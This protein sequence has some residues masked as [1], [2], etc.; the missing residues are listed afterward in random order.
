MTDSALAVDTRPDRDARTN[1]ASVPSSV[2]VVAGRSLRKYMRTPQV[3]LWATLQGIAFMLIFRYVFGGAIDS[4][5][6]RYVDF[7]VPGILVAGVLFAGGMA[8]VGVAQ[9]LRQ[10]VYDRFRSLPMPRSSIVA[11]RVLADWVLVT[12]GLAVT[13]LVAFLIG[14]RVQTDL[15]S[16]LAAFGIAA[17]FGFAMV[18]VFMTIG[19][20]TGDPQAA[21]GVGFLAIPLSFASSAYVP[22]SSMPRWLQV[23]AE[24]QPITIVI[25]AL[26][27]LTQGA[28]AEDLLGRSTEYYVVAALIWIAAITALFSVLAIWRFNRT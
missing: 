7:M 26:R 12:W 17:L 19:L 28:A 14:F 24:Y 13:A 16:A 15:G 8:A 1:Q 6:L 3:L 10:G 20:V 2:A 11:G 5:S 23:F 21:E 22:V 4:G 27:T 18:W 9:D 25:N